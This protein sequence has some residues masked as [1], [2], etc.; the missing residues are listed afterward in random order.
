MSRPDAIPVRVLRFA[1]PVDGPGL[2]V[3]SSCSSRVAKADSRFEIAYLPWLRHH[4]I[5]Y[6]PPEGAA[7]VVMVPECHVKSWDPASPPLA[8]A[9]EQ[10]PEVQ[11]RR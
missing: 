3:A 8:S 1:V 6:H 2:S 10:A 4:Q 11:R 9:V 7:V 5:T